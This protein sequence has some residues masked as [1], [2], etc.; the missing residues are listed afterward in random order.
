MAVS[1]VN[2]ILFL[3]CGLGIYWSGW[4]GHDYFHNP[5]GAGE[6]RSAPT[7]LRPLL[8]RGPGPV[9]IHAVFWEGLGL[10]IV[11][12]GVL[13]IW[14]LAD[15]QPWAQIL[16]FVV[17]GSMVLVGVSWAGAVLRARRWRSKAGIHL[18]APNRHQPTDKPLGK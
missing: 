2:L 5:D 13:D 1:I 3:V 8:R 14:G 17:A 4:D 11:A 15:A 12:A 6:W 10:A 9:I 18:D 7:L 16:T